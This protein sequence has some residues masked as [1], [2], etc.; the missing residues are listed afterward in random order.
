MVRDVLGT[1][2]GS[3]DADTSSFGTLLDAELRTVMRT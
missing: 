2:P 3:S 1:S